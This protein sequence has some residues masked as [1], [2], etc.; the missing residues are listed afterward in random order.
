MQNSASTGVLLNSRLIP[1]N[2]VTK[3]TN[4]SSNNAILRPK[5][6]NSKSTSNLNHVSSTSLNQATI[7]GTLS[8]SP[9]A[10]ILSPNSTIRSKAY[11][12]SNEISVYLNNQNNESFH[13]FKRSVDDD[14]R[15]HNNKNSFISSLNLSQQQMNDLFK[16]PHTF[17]YLRCKEVQS[18]NQDSSDGGIN[19]SSVYNLELVTLDQIDKNFYFTLSK[20]GVTQ[21][22]NKVSSFTSLNQWERE[23]RLFYK[24]VE[25]RFFKIYKR[26]KVFDC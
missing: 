17:F 25:I 26:W 24:I 19:V 5:I 1:E 11:N 10:L 16:V 21:F 15:V 8:N 20:E 12:K 14:E 6:F 9:S 22:R 23:Y 4:S 2:N 18:A 7:K 3:L 13:E